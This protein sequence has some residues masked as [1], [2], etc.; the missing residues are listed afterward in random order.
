MDREKL[1]DNL[2]K[3]R[4]DVP[5]LYSKFVLCDPHKRSIGVFSLMLQEFLATNH[6]LMLYTGDMREHAV[7]ILTDNKGKILNFY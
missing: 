5:Y 7:G 6:W 1:I 4:I 2:R 3:G